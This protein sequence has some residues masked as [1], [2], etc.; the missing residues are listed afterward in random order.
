MVILGAFLMENGTVE[1]WEVVIAAIAI[2]SSFGPTAALSS[3]S[4][5]LHHTLAAGNR[6]LDLLEEEPVVEDVENGTDQCQGDIV[7]E[8]ISFAYE[9]KEEVVLQDFSAVFSENKIH[10]CYL[11]L[12]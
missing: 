5:N 4:N 6:V 9:E 7:C 1:G 2:M 11:S 3:L 8:G 12:P 10:I